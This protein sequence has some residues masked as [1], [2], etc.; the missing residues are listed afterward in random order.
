[1]NQN[2]GRALLSVTDKTGIVD[3]AYSLKSMGYE[4]LS[5][6]ATAATLR[7][8]ELEV[9]EVG[10]ASSRPSAISGPLSLLDPAILAGIAADRSDP[11]RM[12]ELDRLGIPPLDIVAV[13]LYPVAD[14][15][16]DPALSQAEILDYIDVSG[17]ALL[18]AAA[19]NFRHVVCLC[20]PDDYQP[21]L[22]SLRQYKRLRLERRQSLAAKAFHYSAYYDTTVAQYLGDKWDKLPDEFAVGLKKTA[23]LRYGENPQQQGALYTLS[24]ARPWGINAATLVWGKPLSYNHYLDIEIA[25]ALATDIQDA[26]CAVVKHAAPAGA[27]SAEKL[28][29]AARAAYRCDPRGADRGTAA[30]NREVDEDTA[31]FFAEEYV[32]LIAAPQFSPKAFS[33]LK[34]KKDIRLVT[35]PSILIS[36]HELDLR[37][38]AG[39]VMVQDR[40]N[41]PFGGEIKNVSKRA[42]NELEMKSLKLAWLTAKECRTHAAVICRGSATL[43]IGGGQTARLDALRLALVKSQERHPIL[44]AGLPLVLASDGTLSAEHVL[45]AAQAGISAIIEP[46]GSSEDKDA[47]AAADERGLTLL[48]TG[49]R[50]F[51]H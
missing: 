5:F 8:A 30:V 44:T 25:W 15:I 37:S 45:E 39:G 26:A 20:D 7:Q 2:K 48:F 9:T 11:A 22:E 1:M 18:R 27:A 12:G 40:D 46:G 50:H 42:P 43:G 3:F 4:I 28:S 19:R 14:I 51:R 6:G 36:A 13:N 34:T 24:G 47:V 16:S 17:S 35:L 10:P 31:V 21:V 33:V 38:V 49:M 32:G 41:Q 29:E 23:D